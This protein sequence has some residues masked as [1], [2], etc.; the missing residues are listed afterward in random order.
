MKKYFEGEALYGDDFST[1]QIKNWFDQ[2]AEAYAELGSKNKNEYIYI[3]HELNK[4]H[5]YKYILDNH[6]KNVM[7]FGGAYGDELIP[8]I[9][10][11]ENITILEPSEQLR[12]KNLMGIPIQYVKPQISGDL[13]FNDN[14]YNLITCFGVL[15]HVPNVSKLIN[16]FYRCLDNNGYLIL[17]E[18][19]ISMGD[20]RKKRK[21]LTSNERGIP[22][23]IFHDMILKSGFK[24]VHKSYCWFMP[25]TRFNYFKTITKKGLFNFQSIVFIDSIFSFF[26][27]W[28]KKYHATTKLRK[29]QPQSVFYV[30]KKQ[31]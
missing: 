23:Q 2:E 31:A 6:F 8:I 20:W 13:P 4:Y 30:L 3:Y 17:R 19:I 21:N 12:A 14:Q 15:H 5:G 25:I 1:E 7:S 10:K 16:E 9:K 27:S 18:P 28:N 22:D 11:I 29:I 26:F 24:V